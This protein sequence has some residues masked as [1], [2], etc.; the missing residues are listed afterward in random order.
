M[1]VFLLDLGY[2]GVPSLDIFDNVV[3]FIQ[4]EE[5]KIE[6]ETKKILGRLSNDSFVYS[7]IT[8]SATCNRVAVLDGHMECVSV[9]FNSTPP[10]IDEII[11]AFEEY[12]CVET[13]SS[14]KN[15]I[16][17]SRLENRPQPRLDRESQ[18]GMSVVVGRVRKCDVLDVKFT[19]LV[20]NTILGAAGSAIMNAEIA[21]NLNLI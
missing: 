12:K 5:S 8:V 1:Q 18:G 11:S 15:P 20:H 4:D 16:L 2:P 14:P 21:K 13:F 3:P 7:D 10:S 17:V 9:K 19:L 6:T